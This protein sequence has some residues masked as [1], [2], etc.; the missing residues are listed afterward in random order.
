MNLTTQN[1]ANA[2]PV[3]A[4]HAQWIIGLLAAILILQVVALILAFTVART[5]VYG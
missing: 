1:Q 2:G 4:S 5:G 3:T